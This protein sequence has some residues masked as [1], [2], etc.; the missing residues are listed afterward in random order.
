MDDLDMI[1]MESEEKMQKALEFLKEEFSG[2]NTGKASPAMVDKITVDYYGS[3]TRIQQ[4]GNISIPEPRLLVI[5]PFDP[6]CLGEIT[7]AILAANIGVT[8]MNDGRII[9]IP[10]PELSEERRKEMVKIAGRNAEEQRI[11]IRNIRR[12][13]NDSIK[14]LEKAGDITEDDRDQ[15]LSEV[16]KLT[17]KFVKEVD[18]ALAAKEKDIL[19]D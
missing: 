3:P 10:V 15:N 12:D 7:K 18:D 1:T 16:Q 17:D 9:R 14:S 6:S 5:T 8:P 2:L 4:L 19:A 11:A 13:A